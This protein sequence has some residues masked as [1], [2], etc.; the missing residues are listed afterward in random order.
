M[1]PG[2]TTKKASGE[3][4]RHGPYKRKPKG[5][6]L[7]R[8]SPCLA[9]ANLGPGDDTRAPDS[10]AD[11]TATSEDLNINKDK[12]VE[13]LQVRIQLPIYGVGTLRRYLEDA[14]WNSNVAYAAFLADFNALGAGPTVPANPGTAPE[15]RERLPDNIRRAPV[16]VHGNQEEQRREAMRLLQAVINIDR[17]P[18]NRLI[19]TLTEAYFTLILTGW[20][21]EAAA[22][23]WA[24]E[25]VIRWQI[26]HTFD[27]FRSSTTNQVGID[28]R[29]ALFVHATGRDDWHSIRD[30]L[31]AHNQQFMRAIRAWYRSGMPVVRTFGWN[32]PA[33]LHVGRRVTYEG[34]PRSP[35]PSDNDVLPM[36]VTGSVW[37]PDETTFRP[38]G[39]PP[40]DPL[41]QPLEILRTTTKRKRGFCFMPEG[42]A[43]RAGGIMPQHF[44]ID[45]L[46]NGKYV[47]NGFP[48][49]NWYRPDL[50][51]SDFNR[52]TNPIFNEHNPHHIA[53]LGKWIRQQRSR[54]EG[55]LKRATPQDFSGKEK[56]LLFDLCKAHLENVLAN[57]PGKTAAD[58]RPLEFRKGATQKL[59]KDF[60]E[61][62]EGKVFPG[63]QSGTFSEPRRRRTGTAL[64]VKCSRMKKFRAA[65]GFKNTSKADDDQAELPPSRLSS[66]ER[67]LQRRQDNMAAEDSIPHIDALAEAHRRHV[68]AE[69][70]Q[71]YSDTGA[72]F[73]SEAEVADRVRLA[74]H[75]ELRD[76][77]I[78]AQHAAVVRR[79]M[80]T[81]SMVPPEEGDAISD[82]EEMEVDEEDGMGER[83]PSPAKL[84]DEIPDL[85]TLDWTDCFPDDVMGPQAK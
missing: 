55:T 28:E 74:L 30:F 19:L 75:A 11:E 22:L 18:N 3:K 59:E 47:P 34:V 60:N 9:P 73:P 72:L 78:T 50:P 71:H 29:T 82:G 49:K 66:R 1:A 6:S 63:E 26:H 43:P 41:A 2:K 62:F 40:N 15:A 23:R 20:D 61:A 25:D 69:A 57:N 32:N 16:I 56:K 42:D 21:V 44:S 33:R 65:F 68:R 5:K 67:A 64:K 77:K 58:F 79:L 36:H 52:S 13:A 45:Y 70:N 14:N 37:A 39:E 48:W 12:L 54:A 10:D 83:E 81:M 4:G 80:R 53:V 35:M 7:S 85:D 38:A 8:M 51:E 27:H 17:D 76:G 24:S 31:A 46:Q 84:D